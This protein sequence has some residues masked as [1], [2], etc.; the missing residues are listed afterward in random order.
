MV[1]TVSSKDLVLNFGVVRTQDRGIVPLEPFNWQIDFLNK[2]QEYKKIIILKS[3]DI[4]SST[5]AVLEMT[6]KVVLY[7]GDFLIASYKKESSEFLFETAKIFLENLMG[8]FKHLYRQDTKNEVILANGSHIKAMEMSEKVGRSYRFRYLLATEMA[9]WEHSKESWQAL[10]GAG[11]K[12]SEIVIESTPNPNSVTGNTFK[13]LLNNPEFFKITV[14]YKN[15]PYH[16]EEWER[17][18]RKTLTSISFAQEYECSLIEDNTTKFKREWF[19]IVEDYP[20]DCKK[21]RYWDLAGTIKESSD[22]TA[23]C[24]LGFK[25]GVYY[26]IDMIHF[27][28]TPLEIEKIIRQTAMLDGFIKIYMEQEGGGSGVN[29]IDYYQ[30]KILVG[31]DFHPDLKK[32]NKEIRADPV[33]AAAEAGNIKLLKGG[34]NKDFL[35]EIEKFPFGDH[36]DQVDALSGAFNKIIFGN[37]VS[38]F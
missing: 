7:G 4:G 37:E 17:E 34:W 3:R 8:E 32:A 36:D 24:L 15:N 16:D 1:T 38:Q 29:V 12:D 5:I 9:F 11:I 6:A 30:R 26:V 22:Y 27:K 21:V 28:G 31:F 23:G 33:A 2:R 14:D 18:R 13:E 20:K 25:N 10:Q 19:E 35:D